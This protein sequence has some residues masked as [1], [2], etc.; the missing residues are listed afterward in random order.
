MG[1]DT[2]TKDGRTVAQIFEECKSLTPQQRSDIC[3]D[4]EDDVRALATSMGNLYQE[5]AGVLMMYGVRVEVKFYAFNEP[6]FQETLGSEDFYKKFVEQRLK[7]HENDK[8]AQ[9]GN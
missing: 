3:Q 2:E 9:T 1:M 8:R 4:Y 7:G 5:H 6:V